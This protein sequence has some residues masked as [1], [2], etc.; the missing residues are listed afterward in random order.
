MA[1]INDEEHDFRFENFQCLPSTHRRKP[2]GHT[3]DCFVQERVDFCIVSSA[4]LNMGSRRKVWSVGMKQFTDFPAVIHF[5]FP[6][7]LASTKGKN[8]LYI[9]PVS[10]RLSIIYKQYELM[11]YFFMYVLYLLVY[12]DS[13]WIK[14]SS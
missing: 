2:S 6:S 7:F 4:S 8:A 12:L 9:K 5:H 14:S 11:P 13:V 10:L 1:C 3:L